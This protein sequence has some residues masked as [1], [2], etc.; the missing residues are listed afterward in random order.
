[1][2]ATNKLTDAF[3]KRVVADRPAKYYDGAG[4][5][6]RVT[7]TAKV[8][9]MDYRLGGRAQTYVIGPYPVVGLK[10]ARERR[11]ALKARLAAGLSP[12]EPATKPSSSGLS[13]QK[14][15][16]QFW[17]ARADITERYRTNATN[18]LERYIYPKLGSLSLATLKRSDVLAALTVIES[19]GRLDYVRKV[20]LWLSAVLDWAVER[21]YT[22]HN[23]CL[24][25]DPAKAFAR[26]T[27][28]HQAALQPNEMEKLWQRLELE[29]QIQSAMA[30]RLLA[31]TWV[32]TQELRGMQWSEIEGDTWR[33]P[34]SRMKRR[35][36]HLVPLSRQA[37][38]MIAALKRR[39]P[40]SPYVFPNG[41]SLD[42]PMS[43]NAVL[44]L[45][46]RMGF[47]GAA[48]GHGFRATASTWAHEN[49]YA[50]EIIE[51]QLAH[52]PQD[53]IA[54]AYNRAAYLK[55][56]REML[57]AYSD[58]LDSCGTG[59]I[60]PAVTSVERSQ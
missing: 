57:Q 20:R 13:V 2:T 10:D 16:E 29:G 32:R 59:G 5:H 15:C 23:V 51:M 58:F 27:V 1:M 48:T 34:A 38:A 31:M 47:K 46:H 42:R 33:I 35:K 3:C 24:D 60:T 25:I 50:S 53:K 6:L 17:G 9:R 7:A 19:A 8:W 14:A 45:L 30:C 41:R 11:D 28:V 26:K 36:D 37:Q 49:G 22:N 39:D 52:T 21:E 44:Y 12:K 55:P 40:G 18:A 56:R 43:E 4:L 54:A